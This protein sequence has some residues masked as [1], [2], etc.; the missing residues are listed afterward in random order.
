MNCLGGYDIQEEVLST[1]VATSTFQPQ[2][3]FN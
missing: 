2:E 1:G 3:S